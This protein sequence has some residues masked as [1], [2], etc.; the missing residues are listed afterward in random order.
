MKAMNPVKVYSCAERVEADMLITA[1][2]NNKIPAYRQGVGSG[3]YMDIYS[4][5]S[6]FGENI[7]VDEEDVKAAREV[8]ESI[9]GEIPD[10]DETGENKNGQDCVAEPVKK[11]WSPV[12]IFAVIG[13]LVIIVSYIF[14]VITSI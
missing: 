12:R 13:L 6:I 5:N 11:A 2:E 4:G 1:L 7:F 10:L 14:S 3:G 9:V 8:I